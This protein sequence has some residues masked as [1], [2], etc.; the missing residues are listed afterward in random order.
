M[1][2]KI[3]LLITTTLVIFSCKQEEPTP[4]STPTNNNVTSL[5]NPPSNMIGEYYDTFRLGVRN[6]TIT[7]TDVVYEKESFTDKY[8]NYNLKESKG[9]TYNITT[10]FKASVAA[11]DVESYNLRL[12]RDSFII[13]KEL[14]INGKTKIYLRKQK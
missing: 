9:N 3:I 11:T 5:L 2:N 8:K 13:L 10:E 6:L 1:K 12:W 7:S 4:S 14:K